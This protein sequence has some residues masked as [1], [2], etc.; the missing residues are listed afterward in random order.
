[1]HAGIGV[2]DH[3]SRTEPGEDAAGGRFPAGNTAAEAEDEHEP[4]LQGRIETGQLPNPEV[5]LVSAPP[6][7]KRAGGYPP[8]RW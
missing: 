2:E 4:S 8:A 6:Q 3:R 1:M 5:R 7:E